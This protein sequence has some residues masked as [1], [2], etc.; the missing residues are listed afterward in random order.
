VP[1]AA[2]AYLPVKR[3]VDAVAAACL[4]IV[5]VPLLAVVGLAV[6]VG[7]GSPVLFRQERVT[8]GGRRFDLLKFRTMRPIDPARG[9]V[10]DEQRLTRLGRWL[11][12]TSLDELP[13][14]WNI[15]VGDMSVVGPR[16]LLPGY[17]PLFSAA[18]SRR[19][20]VR[21]GLTGLAQ[22]SGR[23]G[24][25]WDERFDLDQRYVLLMGP[26]LDLT[27]I[28]Q[29]AWTV[30][31]RD[32]VD[33][34]H[35]ATTLDFAGPLRTPRL[36]LVPQPEG[37]S[38]GTVAPG[39]AVTRRWEARTPTDTRIAR[40]VATVVQPDAGERIVAE[41]EVSGISPG[42]DL[43]LVDDLILLLVNHIRAAGVGAARIDVEPQAAHLL[44]ALA[45]QGFQAVRD[46][47]PV[48]LA[49]H[50]RSVDEPFDDTLTS[51]A[52]R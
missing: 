46:V 6:R 51:G 38:G 49:A 24:L 43:V 50:I 9:W 22:V 20:G 48:R 4:L 39:A 25:P 28:A 32:G 12:A 16:P 37:A 36:R 33:V 31:R 40:C 34:D 26:L 13:S 11:R 7:L 29:T 45:K 18:Q 14:L 30:L 27:I 2:S 47:D 44:R 8:V 23:N 52:E 5:L 41:L 1:A 19:H 42:C 17:L 10:T 21:A 35:T 3:A 15:L